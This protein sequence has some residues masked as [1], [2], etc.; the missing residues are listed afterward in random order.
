MDLGTMEFQELEKK[1]TNG[2]RLLVDATYRRNSKGMGT[3][4]FTKNGIEKIG[5]IIGE[6]H[7][8][9]FKLFIN[10]ETQSLAFQLSQ[11]GKFRFSGLERNSHKLSYNDLSQV[12]SKEISYMIAQVQ[13]YA[14]VLVPE[15]LYAQL[16]TSTVEEPAA[17]EAQPPVAETKKAEES[18]S[19]TESSS[20]S[21]A[22]K[23]RLKKKQ[24]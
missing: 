22:K 9:S 15:E 23:A 3:L 7:S 14:F 17:V 4:R 16:Q 8:Q 2:R 21:P 19:S 5:K 20:P 13:G 11:T 1:S 6:D 18:P 10:K 24:S 12:F